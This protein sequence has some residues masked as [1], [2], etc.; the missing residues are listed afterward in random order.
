MASPLLSQ[1]SLPLARVYPCEFWFHK[2]MCKSFRAGLVCGFLTGGCL[3]H[4]IF[5]RA[6]SQTE[7]QGGVGGFLCNSF[8]LPDSRVN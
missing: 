5:T 2:P 7:T 4:G 6:S 8:R 3:A 1:G